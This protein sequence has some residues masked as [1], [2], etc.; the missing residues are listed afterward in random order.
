MKQHIKETLSECPFCSF[1]FAIKGKF[2][3][4]R[5]SPRKMVTESPTLL[6]Q[7]PSP[8]I[9]KTET[10]PS[11]YFEN[12]YWKLSGFLKLLPLHACCHLFEHLLLFA[13]VF[14]PLFS[15]FNFSDFSNYMWK[16]WFVYRYF[17]RKL[18]ICF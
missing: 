6:F 15:F 8:Y 18:P 5:K 14:V 13:T 1:T 4:E 3:T 2:K 10:H 11:M 9:Q 12:Q 7:T 17:V 16:Y